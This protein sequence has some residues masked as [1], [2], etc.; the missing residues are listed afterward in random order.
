MSPNAAPIYR[1]NEQFEPGMMYHPRGGAKYVA[2]AE[3]KAELTA[4]GY[5]DRYIHQHFPAVYVH[6]KHGKKTVESADH[7]KQLGDGWKKA[8]Y[9]AA[10]EPAAGGADP[11]L[12]RLE[13]LEE[14]IENM[15]AIA[16]ENAAL[17]AKIAEL[18]AAAKAKK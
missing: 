9:E 10:P 4:Q 7:L 16:Q 11:T 15:Q 2:T 17:R 13:A 6:E 8:G 3:Q 18:E 1:P 14:E 5:M 12:E